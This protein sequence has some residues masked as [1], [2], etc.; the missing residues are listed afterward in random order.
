M[1]GRIIQLT[2]PRALNGRGLILPRIR[3]DI[4]DYGPPGHH[5]HDPL[6]LTGRGKAAALGIAGAVGLT[7]ADGG[8]LSNCPIGGTVIG[9][10]GSVAANTTSVIAS[11][12]IPYPFLIAQIV[13]LSDSGIG[14]SKR[15]EL[16]IADDDDQ[17]GGESTTGTNPFIYSFDVSMMSMDTVA[18]N[19]YPNYRV[20]ERDKFV[21]ILRINQTAGAIVIHVSISLH[22]LPN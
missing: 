22:F 14:T 18:R 12:K 8:M 13:V 15:L 20:S 21:K 6:A 16:R 3:E 2:K 9:A 10:N 19:F 11:K 5:L 4:T 7:D 17:S 1:P